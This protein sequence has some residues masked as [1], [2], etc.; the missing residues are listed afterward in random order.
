M[1]NGIEIILARMDTHPDEFMFGNEKWKFIYS[2]YYRDSLSEGEK[3]AIHDRLKQLRLEE[4]NQKVLQ[5]LVPQEEQEEEWTDIKTGF[6][7]APMKREGSAVK[8]SD[9]IK[10]TL[11]AT[12][13][14][15]A[16]QFGMSMTEYAKN[17]KGLGL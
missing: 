2:D 14:Q 7:S 3:G 17:K 11:K 8:Y 10:T 15:M 12:D 13:A 6:G 1:N 16:K 5:T 9:A 4:F